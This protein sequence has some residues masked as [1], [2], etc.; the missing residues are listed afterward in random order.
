MD[1]D[2]KAGEL[3]SDDRR[4]ETMEDKGMEKNLE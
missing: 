4:K 2:R 3:E 1:K